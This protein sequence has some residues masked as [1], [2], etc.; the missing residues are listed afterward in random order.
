MITRLVPAIFA[1][2]LLASTSIGA[3]AATKPPADA[4]TCVNLYET[5]A[6]TASQKDTGPKDSAR[7]EELLAQLNEQCANEQFEAA[8]ETVDTIIGMVATE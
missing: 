4:E 1:G 6:D 3:Q 8:A 5:T 2:L 7:V